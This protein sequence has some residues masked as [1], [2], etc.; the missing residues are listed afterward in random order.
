MRALGRLILCLVVGVA[1]GLVGGD[2]GLN[3]G[4]SSTQQTAAG[5][6]TVSVKVGHPAGLTV[7]S[8]A[9]A[10][11]LALS[12]WTVPLMVEVTV[13]ETDP[14]PLLRA[15]VD[16]GTRSTL[17][18]QSL[19]ALVRA[20]ERAALAALLGALVLG[21]VGGIAVSTLTGRRRHVVLVALISLLAAAAPA[22][23]AAS[24]V[25]AVGTGA[26]AAPSCPIA[27]Q[28][29]VD[30]AASAATSAQ[31]DPTLARAVAIEAACSPSF[32]AAVAQ[33]LP[34]P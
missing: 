25:A 30:Q 24:Q 34:R 21:L 26:L 2:V 7:I 22:A 33:A 29:S 13:T 17:E 28:L 18:R 20:A 27:P 31:T 5:R 4:G 1:C 8:A 11:Q 15:V 23:V 32:Q 19:D 10:A 9:P 6:A 14:A 12:P 3:L 16:P